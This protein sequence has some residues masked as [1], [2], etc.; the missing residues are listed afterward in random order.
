MSRTAFAAVVIGNHLVGVFFLVASLLIFSGDVTVA[1]AGEGTAAQRV[2]A[3]LLA[4]LLGAAA[5]AGATVLLREGRAAGFPAEGAR[6][7]RSGPFWAGVQVRDG[8]SEVS[9]G[10]GR[11]E[12]SGLHPGVGEL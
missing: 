4:V 7:A 6:I 11:P 2:V 1:G 12:G 8:C 9:F 10:A 5:L 3:G